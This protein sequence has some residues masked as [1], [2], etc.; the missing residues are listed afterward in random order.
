MIS[1]RINEF[2]E[3]KSSDHLRLLAQEQKRG[4][5]GTLPREVKKVRK[6][7]NRRQE[8]NMMAFDKELRPDHR[9]HHQTLRRGVSSESSLSPEYRSDILNRIYAILITLLKKTN[10]QLITQIIIMATLMFL[11]M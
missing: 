4:V 7:H 2:L 5:D 1:L 6:A 9:H 8:W 10:V 3:A 11:V